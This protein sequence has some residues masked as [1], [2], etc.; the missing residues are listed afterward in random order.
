MF[1]GAAFLLYY[2]LVI[3]SNQNTP[4][5]VRQMSSKGSSLVPLKEQ[6]HHMNSLWVKGWWLPYRKWASTSFALKIHSFNNLESRAILGLARILSLKNSP[7]LLSITASLLLVHGGRGK[8]LW[9]ICGQ[10]GDGWCVEN[11][12]MTV[13][14]PR[15][16]GALEVLCS[17]LHTGHDRTVSS[18]RACSDTAT[19]PLNAQSTV[20]LKSHFVAFIFL[21]TV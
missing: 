18:G 2:R 13:N 3:F 16:R 4:R 20:K 14:T 19:C 1:I 5:A 9:S 8:H 15:L 17:H 12:C 10:K 6:T 7:I 11:V 21:L